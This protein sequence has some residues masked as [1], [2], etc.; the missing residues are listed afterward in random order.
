[1]EIKYRCRCMKAPVALMVPD[2]RKGSE[3]ADW[4]NAVQTCVSM[5]HRA[6]NVL[7][8]SEKVDEVMIP[9]DQTS[10]LGVGEVATRN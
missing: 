2:R 10:G 1:M 4:M 5:D 3:I 7:C 9:Y 6:L 8:R